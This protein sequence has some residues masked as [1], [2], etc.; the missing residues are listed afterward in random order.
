MSEEDSAIGD[1]GFKNINKIGKDILIL[2]SILLVHHSQNCVNESNVEDQQ[3][4]RVANN[5]A[6]PLKPE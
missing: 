2:N 1:H 5:D 3:K 6:G 4:S